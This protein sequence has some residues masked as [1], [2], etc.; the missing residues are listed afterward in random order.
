MYNLI[1]VEDEALIRENIVKIIDFKQLG[2]NVIGLCENG[3]V[4]FEMFKNNDID[5]VITDIC[6]PFMDGIELAEKIMS[7]NSSVKILILTGYDDFEYAR[8][9]L[10][11][12]VMEYILKP[13]TADE[14]IKILKQI[15]LILDK[16]YKDN[17]SNSKSLNDIISLEKHQLLNKLVSSENIKDLETY[18]QKLNI[19]LKNKYFSV[20]ILRPD[21]KQNIIDE[22]NL[23]GN[24]MLSYMISNIS[25]ELSL[26]YNIEIVFSDYKGRTIIIIKNDN[27][28][29]VIDTSKQICDEIRKKIK[30]T[31]NFSVSAGVGGVYWGINSIVQSF[32]EASLCL[33]YE[34]FNM[35][36]FT[37][38]YDEKENNINLQKFKGKYIEQQ[39]QNSI[40]TCDKKQLSE[41]LLELFDIFIPPREFYFYIK[42]VAMNLVTL[43]NEMN[44]IEFNSNLNGIEDFENCNINL[45]YIWF[46]NICTKA[47]D[48]IQNVADKDEVLCNK[49]MIYIDKNYN[50]HELSL[51]SVCN[52]L[53]VSISYFSNLFK[54]KKEINF[55]E[56]LTNLRIKKAKEML[57]NTDKS[58]NDISENL[59]Y[60]NT[61]YFC[62]VFKKYTTFTP[63]GFRNNYNK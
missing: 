18:V 23:D 59:G 42:T 49:A 22:L 25:C 46:E 43:M 56:Y 20:A 30:S 45:M 41:T 31:L 26:L 5:L 37:I 1:I 50:D 17:I 2:F 32:N 12:K 58:I 54:K 53:N 35:Y 36:N 51:L 34:F 8:R 19:Q 44:L 55:I 27:K 11:C 47:I 48:L 33:E 62:T 40:K 60:L 39:I 7:I 52:Y 38:V 4:A 6:M 61:N 15:K 14:M 29:I 3:I 10:R 9:A 21:N 57:I 16:E 28:K 24:E 63:L 13:V